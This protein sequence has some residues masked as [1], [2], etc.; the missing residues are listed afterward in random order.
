M[1]IIQ[2]ESLWLYKSNLKEISEL[3][4]RLVQWSVR[5]MGTQKKI[6]IVVVVIV[7]ASTH[8]K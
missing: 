2:E 3:P 1:G 7:M 6:I 8:M 5:S 4:W